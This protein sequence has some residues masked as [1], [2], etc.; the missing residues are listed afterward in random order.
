MSIFDLT[1][2]KIFSLIEISIKF[3]LERPLAFR[4][5]LYFLSLIFTFALIFHWIKL[6]LKN[7]DEIG[8]WKG[9]WKLRKNFYFYK[10]AKK[11]W[12]E[13]KSKFLENKKEGLILA[14]NFVNLVLDTFGYEGSLEEKL[15]KVSLVVLPNKEDLKKATEIA[16]IIEEKM[17]NNEEIDLDEKEILLV[18]NQFEISLQNLNIISTQDFLALSQ[19][20]P[21]K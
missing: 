20:Q 13:I 10:N 14:K 15:D 21:S 7:Q 16:K 11:N 5:T 2:G 1:I 8:K 17:R 19:E 6:E 12:E 9:L 18:F 4:Y 3:V